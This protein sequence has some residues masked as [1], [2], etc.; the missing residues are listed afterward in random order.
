MEVN[1]ATYGK[2]S[3]GGSFFG[4]WGLEFLLQICLAVTVVFAGPRPPEGDSQQQRDL[5]LTSSSA[6]SASP[7]ETT[8]QIDK[9]E[10]VIQTEHTKPIRVVTVSPNGRWLASGSEDNT[11]KLWDATTG[12]LLRTLSQ[13]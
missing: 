13:P 4:G 2:E 12:N 1:R 9:P 3:R 7:A 5:G 6:Q 10:P 11:V 8:P